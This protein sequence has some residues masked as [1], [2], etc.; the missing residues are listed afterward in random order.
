MVSSAKSKWLV[1]LCLFSMDPV[2]AIDA[3]APQLLSHSASDSSAQTS[4]ICFTPVLSPTGRFVL[5]TCQSSDIVAGEPGIGDLVRN[6]SSGNVN[7]GVGLDVNGHWG[8]CPDAELGTCGSIG[9]AS[10]EAG[11]QIVFNSGAPLTPDAIPLIPGAGTPYVFLRDE[12]IE[13]TRLLTPPPAG[14]LLPAYLVGT[15]AL[16]GSDEVL[17]TSVFNLLEE[18]DENGSATDLYSRNWSSDEIELISV[19]PN[20]S[21]GDA[22]TSF[23]IFS[24]DGRYVVFISSAGNLTNDNPQ[25]FSNIFLR[26]RIDGITVRLTFP[27]GGGEFS[28]SPIFAKALRITD[29]NQYLLFGASG[30][31]FIPGDDPSLQNLY[32]LN[33]QN[34]AVEQ[35]PRTT[36]GLPPNASVYNGDVSSDGRR[37]VF[38]SSATNLSNDTAPGVFLQDMS[39]NQLIRVSEPLGALARPAGS[40]PPR[41]RISS[42]GSTLAFEWPLF[43]ALFPTV[44]ANQQIYRVAIVGP[45]FQGALPV[46]SLSK[47]IG[48]ITTLVMML[49]AIFRLNG[50]RAAPRRYRACQSM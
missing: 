17:F 27:D 38:V 10:D 9:I 37:L 3:G 22:D 11:Q 24:R 7:S 29:D 13:T 28:S 36:D 48:A 4:G 8:Y 6:D 5:F 16:F 18:T 45:G 49:M 32:L 43:D 46:P 35:L 12:T 39:T 25:H 44:L 26:D 30:A 41:V 2:L 19:A 23:G 34:G 50:V 21:Q 20:G 42:D 14:Q 1:A 15:D 33:L 47:V 40:S 31:S